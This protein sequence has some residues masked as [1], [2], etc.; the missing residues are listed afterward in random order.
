MKIVCYSIVENLQNS[1]NYFLGS[2]KE[3]RPT[4]WALSESYLNYMNNNSD[5]LNWIPDHDYYVK[6]IG[7]L[8]DSIL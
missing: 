5:E 7:R 4:G 1:L 6:L 3:I 2:L 8:V